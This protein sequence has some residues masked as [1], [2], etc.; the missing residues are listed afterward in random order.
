MDMMFGDVIKVYTGKKYI[1]VYI[2]LSNFQVFSNIPIINKLN[3]DC[4]TQL[5]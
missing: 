5:L 1:K 4:V 2:P 3:G